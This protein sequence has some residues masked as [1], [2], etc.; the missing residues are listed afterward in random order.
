MLIEKSNRLCAAE[1]LLAFE[2]WGKLE[3]TTDLVTVLLRRL[4][5]WPGGQLLNA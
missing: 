4:E 5:Q 1:S 3:G 2:F